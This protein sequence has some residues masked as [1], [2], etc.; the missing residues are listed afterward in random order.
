MCICGYFS[1]FLNIMP[2]S[3]ATGRV[4]VISGPSGAGKTTVLRK[5]LER[6]DRLVVS[7]SATTREPRPGE[8]DG[9]DYHFLAPEEFERRRQRSDFLEC[10]EVFNRGVWYG[11]LEDEVGPRLAAGKWVVLEI[12]VEGTRSVLKRYPDALT[13]FVR[14]ESVDELERRLR[15]R[16]TEN[17]TALQRRLEVARRELQS[18]DIYRYQVTNQNVDRAVD[19]I[20]DIL[21]ASNKTTMGDTGN[22]GKT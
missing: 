20:L 19:E 3:S 18:A 4:I 2:A 7:V 10:A 12:D 1:R 21:T 22:A 17:E 14:P 6:C 11:T 15:A 5:L 16:G 9:Q 8:I 13:I